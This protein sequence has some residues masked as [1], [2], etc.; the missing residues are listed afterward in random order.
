MPISLYH[1]DRVR[2]RIYCVYANIWTDVYFVYTA[3]L[4]HLYGIVYPTFHAVKGKAST[5][6][7]LPS[8]SKQD[9]IKLQQNDPD[10]KEFY[11]YWHKR[12]KQT[13]QEREELTANART[14]MKQWDKMILQDRLL[15]RISHD[16][17]QKELKWLVLP[18]SLKDKVLTSVHDEIGHQGLKRTIQLTRTRCYWPAMYADTEKWIKTCHSCTLSKMP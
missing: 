18:A 16:G 5:T 17:N 12:Q 10:I 6:F 14:L 3:S 15:Y 11:K 4:H 1:F 2:L 13:S 9:L 7:L 8:Y